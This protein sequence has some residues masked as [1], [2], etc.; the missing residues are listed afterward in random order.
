MKSTEPFLDRFTQNNKLAIRAVAPE[1]GHLPPQITATFG[2][3]LQ[4]SYYFFLLMIDGSARHVVDLQ[5]YDVGNNELLFILPNQIHELPKER[6]ETDYFKIGFD[7]NCLSLLPRQYP[8]LIDPLNSQKIQLTPAAARRLKPV[9]EMLLGLLSSMN[10]EPELILAHLNSLLTEINTAYFATDKS[11]VDSR[12]SKYIAFKAFIEDNLTE[13]PRV[14]DIAEELA[15]NPNSL[16][17]LV[18]HYSGQSPKEYITS[19]LILEARRRLYYR[20]TTTVKELAFQLGFSD[21][22]Y[23]SRLFKKETGQ[24]VGAFFQELAGKE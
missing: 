16:Y 19:R 22:D 2:P 12:L 21:P 24:T 23:F 6:R 11:P 8:F 18:K 17:T 5:A 14:E 15:L 7:K 1:F 10:T 4:R 13:Q 9:S 3:T 20:E